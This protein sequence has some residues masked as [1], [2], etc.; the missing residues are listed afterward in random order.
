MTPQRRG[1]GQAWIIAGIISLSAVN[2]L[3][4]A[5]AASR[6]VLPSESTEMLWFVVFSILAGVWL[7]NDISSDGSETARQI[8]HYALFLFWPLVLPYHLVRS[9]GAEGFVLFVGFV[10]TYLAPWLTQLVSWTGR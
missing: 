9:R 10:A 5:I 4:G 3:L 1:S 6:G 7:K 2:A 8:P